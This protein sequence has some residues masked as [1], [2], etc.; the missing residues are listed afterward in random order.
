MDKAFVWPKNFLKKP[1]EYIIY[2]LARVNTGLR[3]V[4]SDLL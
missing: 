4:L 1:S 3:D 2:A